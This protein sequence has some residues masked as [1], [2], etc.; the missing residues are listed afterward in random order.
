MG[1]HCKQQ[2]PEHGSKQRKRHEIME[3]NAWENI[4]QF[5]FFWK[6]RDSAIAMRDIPT[7]RYY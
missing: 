6:I 4:F 5:R 1:K 7:I 3:M 2:V